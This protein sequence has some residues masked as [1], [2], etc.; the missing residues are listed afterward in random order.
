MIPSIAAVESVQS[1]GKICILDI[2]VQGAESVKNSSLTPIYIFIA[3]PSKEQLESRLRGRGTEKEESILKRLAGA[4]KEIEYSN[5]EG[6]FDKIFVNDD[7]KTT[8]NELATALKSWYPHLK[9]A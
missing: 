1:S 9:E 2:D 3:P 6:N 5:V 8:E 4:A 7:L